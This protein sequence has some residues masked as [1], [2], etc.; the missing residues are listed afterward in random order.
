VQLDGALVA[1]PI[2]DAVVFQVAGT[3]HATLFGTRCRQ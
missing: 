2:V 3:A 1:A